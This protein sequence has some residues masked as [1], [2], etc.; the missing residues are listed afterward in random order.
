MNK[1][2]FKVGVYDDKAL[3]ALFNLNVMFVYKS[4]PGRGRGVYTHA[5]WFNSN[6]KLDKAHGLYPPIIFDFSSWPFPGFFSKKR[7]FKNSHVFQFLFVPN[8][9]NFSPGAWMVCLMKCAVDSFYPGQRFKEAVFFRSRIRRVTFFT[10]SACVTTH[11]ACAVLYFFCMAKDDKRSVVIIVDTAH[12][13]LFQI[14]VT[15]NLPEK[16][17]NPYAIIT[18][19]PHALRSVL[20]LSIGKT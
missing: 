12:G 6:I 19:T 14:I 2:L 11:N 4:K 13:V 15:G 9:R 7:M 20:F 5:S 1:R 16:E 8:L 3:T 17:M 18:G 10:H